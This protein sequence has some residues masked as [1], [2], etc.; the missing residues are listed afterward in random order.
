M[1]V[2]Q[3]RPLLGPSLGVVNGEGGFVM[4]YGE[5]VRS[6]GTALGRLARA[7]HVARA[8]RAERVE[9]L[10]RSGVPRAVAVERVMREACGFS[11]R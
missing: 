4:M 8:E 2:A 10:V 1:T 9:V 11:V 5:A 7:S 6:E 3:G